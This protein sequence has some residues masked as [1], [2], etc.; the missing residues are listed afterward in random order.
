[1]SNKIYEM[2]VTCEK[3]LVSIQ[4]E[5]ESTKTASGLSL[6]NPNVADGIESAIVV[7]SGNNDQ[8]T[9]GDRVLIYKGSGKEFTNPD[10]GKRYRV[11]ALSE[12][13]VIL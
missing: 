10:D 6:P 7:T 1:M 3:V 2:K 12:I 11:I 13:I 5:P 4:K 9:K 8:V